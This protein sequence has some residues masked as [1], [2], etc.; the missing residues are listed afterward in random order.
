MIYTLGHSTL[1]EEA[2]IEV[3]K[4]VNIIMDIRSHPTS[5]WPQFRKE[6]MEEWVPRFGKAYEWE[7]GLGGWDKRHLPTANAMQAVG[8]DVQVYAKGKFPKQRIAGAVG[9]TGNPTWTNQ[10]LYDYSWFMTLPEFLDAADNLVIRGQYEN[11]A[12]MCCE[13][14]W[15]KCHRSMVAD[16]LVWRGGQATHLQPKMTDHKSALGNRLSRY[17][18]RIIRSW[19]DWADTHKI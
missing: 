19:Q 14:L 15:W 1:V 17:D 16:Y 12:I 18:P 5:K 10:G 9:A 2:F 4:P 6:N 8:V 3:A 7:P 11:I 13:V